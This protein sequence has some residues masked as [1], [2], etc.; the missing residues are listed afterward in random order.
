MPSR[1]MQAQV[2]D[3]MRRNLAFNGPEVVQRVRVTNADARVLMMQAKKV[4]Q[5]VGLGPVHM[6]RCGGAGVWVG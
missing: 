3:S 5:G 6:E 1:P 4:G 2:C